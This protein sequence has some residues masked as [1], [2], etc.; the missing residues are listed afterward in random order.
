MSASELQGFV[1]P[2]A[3]DPD[4]PGYF[5][6]ARATAALLEGRRGEYFLYR[7]L[8]RM[9]LLNRAGRF[10]FF[11]RVIYIPLYYPDSVHIR[12]FSMYEGLRETN[13]ANVIMRHLG[14]DATFLDCGAAFGQICSRVPT[15][16][17]GL[18]Q[19]ISVEPNITSVQ[20]LRANQ[21]LLQ[22]R[23][24]RVIHAAVSDFSGK[25]SLEFPHG[26]GDPHSAYIRPDPDGDIDVMRID[27]LGIE[28]GT[29][30]ALKL[31]LEGGEFAA[32]Q[33]GRETIARAPHFCCFV[34][35]HPGVMQRIGARP[36]DLLR[37][38][39]AIRDMRWI[40]ADAPLQEIDLERPFFEQVEPAIY[41]VIGIST[42]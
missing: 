18:R 25:G 20:V 9:G 7:L 4:V 28:S 26:E 17:P 33:G 21:A 8:K 40:L 37:A 29:D 41:D 11:D 16:C 42:G 32:I 12:D 39:S 10:R 22:G 27:D 5:R 19:V 24:T 38:I 35:I 1:I 2:G 13:F 30:L 14:D 6:L 15:L 23:R 36:E 34:E 31:D 3:G